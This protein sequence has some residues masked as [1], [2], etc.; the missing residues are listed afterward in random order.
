MVQRA[1]RSLDW[2]ERAVAWEHDRFVDGY[3][4]DGGENARVGKARGAV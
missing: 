2:A 4:A 1:S 3:T